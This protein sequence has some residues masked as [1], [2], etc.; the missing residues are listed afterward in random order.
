M[1]GKIQLQLGL[2][3]LLLAGLT[4]CG[5]AP[6]NVQKP[7]SL[8]SFKQE[9]SLKKLWSHSAGSMIS[10]GGRI[11]LLLQNDSVISVSNAGTLT[12]FN[13]NTGKQNWSTSLGV[14]I[15]AGIGGNESILVVATR[16][17]DITAVSAND[18]TVR[19][20]VNI[21]GEVLSPPAPGGGKFILQ[22]VDGRVM[23]LSAQTGKTE[24]VYERTVPSLSLRGNSG[25]V[26]RQGLVVVGFASGHVVGLDV[27][28]GRAIWERV[29]A[30]PSG[31][32][33]VERLVDIDS[34]PVISDSML[35]AGSYQGKLVAIDLRNGQTAWSRPLSVYL[36]MASDGDVLFVVNDQGVILAIDQKTGADKWA[37]ND[38]KRRIS[39]GPAIS[40]NAVVLGDIEGYI[41]LLNT[42]TGA[43]VGRYKSD[44]SRVT[45]NLAMDSKIYTSTDSGQVQVYSI[46]TP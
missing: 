40:S 2:Q 41:H 45:S 3:I 33:D 6:S 39:S 23:A 44:S 38:L 37:Q 9:L 25:P 21:S 22:T 43:V 26:Y 36:P 17:G 35:F 16:D 30:F 32:S 4:A 29:V 10:T 31:K 8:G 5:G 27:R 20:T 7:D 11:Q 19:W 24:W 14:A 18:G 15:S 46:T 1:L 12:S 34:P 13:R 42:N 28:N